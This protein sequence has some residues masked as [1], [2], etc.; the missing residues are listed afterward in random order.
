M[1]MPRPDP[2]GA[3]TVWVVPIHGQID[4][5]TLALLTRSIRSLEPGR[6]VLL[7]DIDTPGGRVDRMWAIAQVIDGATRRGISTVAWVR[8]HATSAGSLITMSCSQIYMSPAGTIGSATP[9]IPNP[10]GG[11]Q[12]LPQ[13]EDVREKSY[14]HLRSSF[15][16]YAESHG[17][18]APL[19]EAMID[20]RVRVVEVERPVE[21]GGYEVTLVSG[22]DWDSAREMGLPWSLK[23]VVVDGEHLANLTAAEAVRYG[24]ADGIADSL[25]DAIDQ[26][27]AGSARVREMQ[28]TRSESL[29]SW[30]DRYGMAIL[31]LAIMCLIMEFKMPGFGLPGIASIALFALFLI[32]RYLVGVADIPHVIAISLGLLLLLT[33]F[34]LLPGFIWPG[35]VGGVLLLGGMAMVA[36]GP[37]E[38]LKYPIGRSLAIDASF[39]ACLWVVGTMMVFVLTSKLF[40][41]NPF[42]NRLANVPSEVGPA[43]AMRE[44]RGAHGQ[45]AIGMGGRAL[46]ALRPV[47]KVVLTDLPDLEFEARSEGEAIDPGSSVQVIEVQSGRL[48]VRFQVPSSAS[49]SSPEGTST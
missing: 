45:A 43:A 13:D 7:C 20:K 48:L 36:V 1:V 28:M 10:M 6:D 3:S 40:P 47:G 29:A 9:V 18:P 32:G 17:R 8:H 14:S 37:V 31:G 11:I 49:P 33:E 41:N 46:T 42:L 44:A 24:M 16:A 26:A 39:Q 12:A 15:R 4:A 34:F 25:T 5:G 23:S 27:G 38:G 19:A 21:G 35:I 30:L 2:A 22:T